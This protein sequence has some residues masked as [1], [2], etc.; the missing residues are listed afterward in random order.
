MSPYGGFL[1]SFA[2]H[3]QSGLGYEA[4]RAGLVFAPCAV[5]FGLCGYF[6]RRLPARW[7]PFLTPPAWPGRPAL[8]GWRRRCTPGSRAGRC[9]RYAWSTGAGLA[10]AFSPLITHALVRVP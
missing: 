7:Y 2:I 9:C 6:W 8:P 3:L 1:F 10:L 5:V 4:L